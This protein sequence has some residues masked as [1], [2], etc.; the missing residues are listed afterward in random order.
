MLRGLVQYIAM[1]LLTSAFC[2]GPGGLQSNYFS[3]LGQQGDDTNL[4]A[5]GGES[6]GV[7]NRVRG[8]A[9]MASKLTK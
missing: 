2:R 4:V 6:A 7:H 5:D 3:L 9:I 1:V 8:K